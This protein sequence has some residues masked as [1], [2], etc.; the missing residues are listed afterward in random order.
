M[1]QGFG[2]QLLKIPYGNG[3][4]VVRNKCLVHGEE[5]QSIALMQKENV[6]DV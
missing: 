2:G 3:D 1:Q 5:E 6:R 4:P